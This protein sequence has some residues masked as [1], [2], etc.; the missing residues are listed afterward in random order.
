[1][2]AQRLL[3]LFLSAFLLL[4]AANTFAQPE[5]DGRLL[6]VRGFVTVTDSTGDVR[7]LKRGDTIASSDVIE[8]SNRSRAVILFSDGSRYTLR[9]NTTFKID[10]YAFSG[11]DDQNAQARFSILRGALQAVSGL[12]GKKNRQNFRLNTP[13]STIGLRGTTFQVE[14]TR[15]SSGQLQ[16]NVFT[17]EGAIIYSTVI[18]GTGQGT[19]LPESVDASTDNTSLEVDV[20]D[21]TG[22]VQSISVE[23][24]TGLSQAEISG[25]VTAIENMPFT[26][27]PAEESNEEPNEE[28]PTEDL[29]DEGPTDETPPVET[30]PVD[31]TPDGGSP[32]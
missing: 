15:D 18:T 8:T 12:I 1:M 17:L 32:L 25:V 27:E 23:A 16:V 11:T 2:N 6:S 14:L 20:D 22:E 13:I 28:P 7:Q 3:S 10:R 26:P 29:T 4:L 24:G 19:S 21:T 31:T 30:V 5:P 9:S